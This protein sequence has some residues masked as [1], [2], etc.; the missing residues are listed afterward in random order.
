MVL[1]QP[2]EST[3]MARSDL[4]GRT[5]LHPL[6][7]PG[8]FVLFAGAL[9]TD[10][11]YSRTADV[12][13][14]TF[15]SWLIAG[16]LLLGL[17]GAIAGVIDLRGHRVGG[18]AALPFAVGM[19]LGLFNAFVHSRDAWTS[20]VPTGLTLSVLTVIAMA[21]AVLW[22]GSLLYRTAGAIR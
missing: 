17:F 5:P 15:S 16:A 12:T 11:A 21:V 18:A 20:V 7:L 9:I 14:T 22:S 6:W 2:L 4:R 3:L 8:P 10:I 1:S 19:V 13:W